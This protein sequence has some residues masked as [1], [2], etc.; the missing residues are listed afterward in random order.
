MLTNMFIANG[1][2]GVSKTEV[3]P[4]ICYAACCNTFTFINMSCCFVQVSD[5]HGFLATGKRLDKKH[6]NVICISSSRAS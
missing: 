5:H 3:H 4:K 6:G 2:T 1:L